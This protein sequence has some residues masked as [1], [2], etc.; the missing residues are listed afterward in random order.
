M[1]SYAELERILQDDRPGHILFAI[2]R[3][4][5]TILPK[6]FASLFGI[7][8]DPLWHPEGCVGAH[9]CHVMDAMAKILSRRGIGDSRY[10]RDEVSCY[11]VA[12]LTAAMCHDMG[13][14]T[15]TKFDHEKGRW[16]AKGHAQA[17]VCIAEEFLES[18]G[19]QFGHDEFV[20]S[21]TREHMYHTNKVVTAKAVKRLC[22]RLRPASLYDLLLLM[23]ADCSG[24]PPIPAG[25]PAHCRQIVQHGQELGFLPADD[26][27]DDLCDGSV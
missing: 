3:N 18:V 4:R 24:R 1:M 10:R 20:F 22:D 12:M 21:L 11:S 23:Y 8:Q 26:N 9:S 25:L 15:T 14:A 17:G 7:P 6:Q 13:K 27:F 16:T 19:Y 2:R 5:E